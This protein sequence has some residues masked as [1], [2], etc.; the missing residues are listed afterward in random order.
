M[1]PKD[2]LSLIEEASGTSTYVVNKKS[3]EQTILKK[4][5]KLEEVERVMSTDVLPQYEKLME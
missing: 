2:I 3:A 4:Q 1:K 5:Q